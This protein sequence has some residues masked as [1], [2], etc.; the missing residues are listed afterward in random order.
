M[1]YTLQQSV[2]YALTYIQYSPLAVGTGNEPAISIANEIQYMITSAPF[3]WPWNRYETIGISLVAGTQT[4]TV[5]STDFSFMEKATLISAADG[6][7]YEILDVYN[8]ES[9][10]LTSSNT[11][12]LGQPNSCAVFLIN[13]GSNFQVR[14]MGA[15]DQGY[16]AIFTYQRLVT[17]F[18]ALTD[19]WQIPDQ[20]RDI[21]NNL[22]LGEAMAVVDDARSV[23]YRQRGVAALLSKQ[24]GL[25]AMQKDA[26]LEQ[27]WARDSQMQ[28][29][30]LKTQ[31][32][33]IS[34]GV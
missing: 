31:Q 33:S 34:R 23:Q 19:S 20:Y 25:S 5:T 24:Q 30:Q 18:A 13:Y 12:S 17:P 9:L 27:Y 2:N 28:A 14:F 26:F 4:Y 15:P 22:F 1:S 11:N 10:G 6:S 7:V 16:N 8:N 3:T 32:G 21:Y 29:R